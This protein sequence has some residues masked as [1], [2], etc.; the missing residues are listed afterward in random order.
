MSVDKLRTILVG[1][2]HGCIDEFDE[3]V[4]KLSYDPKSDRLILLGDLID[5]GP[6]SVGVVAKARKMNL[7]CV[8]GNHELKFLKWYRSQGSR[9]NVYDR[10]G[11]YSD[12]SDEDVNYISNMSLFISIPEHNTI[13]A[14]AGVRGGISA[15]QQAKDDLC[16]IRYVDNDQKTIS[17]KRVSALGIAA[18][19]ARFWT[20]FWHGPESIVYGHNVHSYE[21]PLITEIYPDV[22]CY[23]LDTGCVFGGRLTAM[24]LETKEIIQ[25][26]AKKVYFESSFEIR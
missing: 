25:V 12:F 18:S 5:R 1:D 16:Y 6:D 8:M 24:I 22:K 3:L 13:V 10:K 4:K 20:D 7:E 17:L 15:L 19:G 14:H 2:I 11:Y 23:G 26:Q 21:E 9:A